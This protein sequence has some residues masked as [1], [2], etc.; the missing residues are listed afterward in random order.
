MAAVTPASRPLR[1]GRRPVVL[2]WALWALAILGVGLVAWFDQLVRPAGR[3][4][5]VLLDANG[6]ISPLAVLPFQEPYQSVA[7]PLAV[8]ALGDLLEVVAVVT[9][10]A[11]LLVLPVG[12]WSLVVR[13]RRARGTERQQLRWVVLAAAL[14]SVAVAALLDGLAVEAQPLTAW[15]VAAFVTL[16]PLAIGAA[17][18]RYRLYDLDRIISRT[19]AYGLLA[20][21]LALG[22]S[23]VVLGLGQLLGQGSSLVVAAATLTVAAAF[24]PLRRRL[25]R[26]LDRRFDRRR[27]H[28]AQ[29][30][31]AFS[32]RLRQQVDL[33]TL[34]AELL[35]VV[36][37]TMQPTMVSLWLRP[38]VAASTKAPTGPRR[39]PRG[40]WSAAG[41]PERQPSG[42]LF[43][44]EQQALAVETAAVAGQ[45]AGGADHPVAGEDDRDRVAAVGHADGPARAGTAEPGGE[46]PVAG[47]VAVGDV[48]EQLPHLPL[49]AGAAERDGEVEDGE[50]AGEV[51][52][53]LL[54]RARER[55]RVGEPVG[56]EADGVP[57][58]ELEVD[59]D[60]R[61]AVADQQQLPDG[62]LDDGVAAAGGVVE[63]D[64]V[65]ADGG[66]WLHEASS[67]APPAGRAVWSDTGPSS[68]PQ[69][70][71]RA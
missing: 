7:N 44:V 57:A 41:R 5:L 23:L 50:V 54:D 19:L 3:R 15:A 10:I 25:R 21:I 38:T 30:I 34:T 67:L 45:G 8:A 68:T 43:E 14:A 65:D 35:T 58:V 26:A 22:Y 31:Q 61:P 63:V 60:Q 47:G 69:R 71:C 70:C 1:P 17:V 49:E 29:T 48:G 40:R 53:Q 36:D 20:L 24:Q 4:E 9:A 33:D 32:A 2:A 18:L 52:V 64:E 56:A 13:F 59:G 42:P 55:R 6:F 12:A 37:Q 16:P 39:E 66:G 27:Y 28:A 51:G 62:G 11:S 46:L